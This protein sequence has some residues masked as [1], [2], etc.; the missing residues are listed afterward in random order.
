VSPGG[1]PQIGEPINVRLGD[2]LLGKADAYAAR[3]KISRAEA[4]RAL[5][6]AALAQL[7]DET[8]GSYA[9]GDDLE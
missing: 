8:I 7:D 1:R 3:E 5:V 2:T 9:Y 4:I 6:R